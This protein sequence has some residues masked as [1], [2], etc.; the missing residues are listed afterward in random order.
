[1]S[2]IRLKNKFI[3]DEEIPEIGKKGDILRDRV[4]NVTVK[5]KII[6]FSTS[7]TYD[8][9]EVYYKVKVVQGAE[10]IAGS[11]NGQPIFV[12]LELHYT[13]GTNAGKW[14]INAFDSVHTSTKHPN[15][16]LIFCN[17]NQGK[18]VTYSLS[19]TLDVLKTEEEPM[20]VEKCLKLPE[21]IYFEKELSNDYTKNKPWN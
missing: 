7:F 12:D 3:W 1:M 4:F 2:I 14:T 11:V 18:R 9:P 6:K 20:V 10:M 21:L 5:E 16:D 15:F 13:L 17:A 19:T 8:L